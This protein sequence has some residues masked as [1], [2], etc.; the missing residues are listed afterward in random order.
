M[1]ADEPTTPTP[2]TEDPYRRATKLVIIAGMLLIFTGLMIMGFYPGHM[3]T[4]VMTIC[5]IVLVVG[6]A[7]VV[8]IIM[9]VNMVK[10]AKKY[11]QYLVDNHIDESAEEAAFIDYI[12][13]THHNIDAASFRSLSL[14]LRS[15]KNTP[16]DTSFRAKFNLFVVILFLVCIVGFP[17]CL[18]I[19]LYLGM[20]CIGLGFA[21]ILLLLIVHLAHKGIASNRK[22]IDINTA[23][24]RGTV[25]ACHISD[26]STFSTGGRR[27]TQT[28]RILSTTYLVYLD[29]DG[30][31]K[32]AYSKQ[33]YNAGD[34]VYVRQNKKLKDMV[35]IDE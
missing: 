25:T 19:N 27:A 6:G 11:N 17:I 8:N 20:A 1:D 15:M 24:Q 18:G 31:T 22:N 13:S 2:L 35:I 28:T 3:F 34:Q 14:W 4:V 21:C 30:T 33:Y 26:E 16:K 5:G 23:P 29:V 10:A 7:L 32:K 9:L 12:N